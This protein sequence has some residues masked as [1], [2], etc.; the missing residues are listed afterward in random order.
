MES[1]K[2][3]WDDFDFQF[4]YEEDAP[5]TFEH[6]RDF[7]DVVRLKCREE[8]RVGAREDQLD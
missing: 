7:P 1:I 6:G 3:R 8:S 2:G 4:L 5:E